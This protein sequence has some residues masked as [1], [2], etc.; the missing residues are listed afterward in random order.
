MRYRDEPRTVFLAHCDPRLCFKLAKALWF[1]QSPDLVSIDLVLRA[2]HNLK[3]RV[4]LVGRRR[5]LRRFDH[6][7]HYF[8]NL[9]PYRRVYGITAEKSSYV[10]FKPNQMF[11]D[12]GSADANGRYV[13]CFGQSMRDFDTFFNAIEKLSLPAAIPQP[14][15]ALLRT[16]GSKFTR[17]LDK[18]PLNLKLL[19]DDKRE[20]TQKQ[21]IFDA[22]LVVLPIRK[23]SI[24]ASGIGTCLNSML[25]GKCVIG[26]EGPGMSDIFGEEM[27]FVPPEN[28]EK[29]AH[30]I[31]EAW[32]NDA[33]RER[34]AE[35]G[36][37]LAKSL[38]GEQD[39]YQRIIDAVA[40]WSQSRGKQRL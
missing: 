9:E 23:E 24:V 38:G 5:L 4:A 11:R 39:L 2:P 1:R 10:P 36:R 37:R 25:A 27:L 14:D 12:S 19:A 28:P 15:F 40:R 34:T 17:P 29:L 22:R 18:L 26:T 33:L 21:M 32:D 6:H 31:Q 8:R 3:S 30:V 7:I 16:H 13:L 20:Q 35:A